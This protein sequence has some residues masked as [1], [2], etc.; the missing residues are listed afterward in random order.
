M[1]GISSYRETI[2]SVDAP[3]SPPDIAPRE[4][5]LTLSPSY[6]SGLVVHPVRSITA[7]ASGILVD[8]EGKPIEWALGMLTDSLGNKLGE[9]FTDETGRFEAYGLDSGE[10]RIGWLTE[11]AVFT[12][13]SIPSDSGGFVD[14]GQVGGTGP[15]GSEP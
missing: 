12:Q 4:S 6:K 13:I 1:A 8:R 11:D 15:G 2:A 9:V 14:L 7:W 5:I 10:F 3:E